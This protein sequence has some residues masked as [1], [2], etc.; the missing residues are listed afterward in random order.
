[1]AIADMK[2]LTAWS[3]SERQLVPRI[4]L[5]ERLSEDHWLSGGFYASAF[6]DG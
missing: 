4:L 3:D 5:T 1:M 6:G 2:W